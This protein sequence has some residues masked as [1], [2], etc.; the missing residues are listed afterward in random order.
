MPG[1]ETRFERLELKVVVDE[2]TALRIG[3]D[4]LPYCR[5]DEHNV[6]ASAAMGDYTIRSLY[7]DTPSLAFY[8]AK[9]RGDS[10]RMKLRIRTYSDDP[11]SPGAS[12][13]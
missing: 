8:R 7:L 3:R 1:F 12:K 6:G 10:E 11:S 13:E 2:A 4:I 9:D 5:A